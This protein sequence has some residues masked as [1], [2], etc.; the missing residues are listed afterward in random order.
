MDLQDIHSAAANIEAGNAAD[1]I[2][3]L[4]Q[5]VDAYP[6]YAAAHLLLARAYRSEGNRDAALRSLAGVQL[7]SSAPEAARSELHAII[8]AHLEDVYASD[9]VLSGRPRA[10][11]VGS[12]RFAGPEASRGTP[13]HAPRSTSPDELAEDL[14]ERLGP[15]AA[16]NDEDIKDLNSLIRRLEGA[17]IQ[18]EPEFG[19]AEQQG[20]YAPEDEDSQEV[21]SET[22]ARIYAAQS[23]YQAAF[24]AYQ[25]LADENPDR[26]D[27]FRRKAREIKEQMTE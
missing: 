26:A 3:V 23:E 1:A 10:D 6:A 19:G 17:R 25:R 27:E 15:P 13:T 4:E 14:Q 21:V 7:W 8:D 22:L 9:D 16:E 24:D 12:D 18:P 11:T 20:G 2:P 5:L